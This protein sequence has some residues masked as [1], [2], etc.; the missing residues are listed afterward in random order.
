M[1]DRSSTPLSSSFGT[2][3]GGDIGLIPPPAVTADSSTSISSTIGAP[4]AVVPPPPAF[5]VTPSTE[6]V[7]Q[8]NHS[9]SI[10]DYVFLLV[11]IK[12]HHL[13]RSSTSSFG[14]TPPVSRH[15]TFPHSF[16]VSVPVQASAMPHAAPAFGGDIN[17]SSAPPTSFECSMGFTPYRQAAPL[18]S[19]SRNHR[20]PR[21]SDP[22]LHP[23]AHLA[24]T[25]DQQD[26]TY[27]Y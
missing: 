6:T 8:G 22:T 9:S 3:F 21:F 16:G 23:S 26:D 15:P 4:P 25:T 11:Q 12:L 14:H 20:P 27:H 1:T 2:T 17:T 18:P 5:F 10:R 24:C 13:H 7:H 19:S